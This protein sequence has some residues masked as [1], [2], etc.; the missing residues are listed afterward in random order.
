MPA[1]MLEKEMAVT[2]TAVVRRGMVQGRA[3]WGHHSGLLGNKPLCR[4]DTSW[5]SPWRNSAWKI[6]TKS[7]TN[8]LSSR[9]LII[10]KHMLKHK[11]SSC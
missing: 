1:E 11:Q 6:V 8:A 10:H 9:F 7:Q 5:G 2:L 3:E 4:N